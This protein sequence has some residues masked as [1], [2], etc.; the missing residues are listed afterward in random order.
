MPTTRIPTPPA[1]DSSLLRIGHSGSRGARRRCCRRPATPQ[2][3]PIRPAHR[4]AGRRPHPG[5]QFAACSTY[6]DGFPRSPAEFVGIRASCTA[7]I[8]AIARNDV[9][10][11][12]SC[13]P[14]ISR[15]NFRV[16]SVGLISTMCPPRSR[17]RA[18][19]PPPGRGTFC[20][21]R[22]LIGS[23]A[24]LLSARIV[25]DSITGTVTPAGTL[26]WPIRRAPAKKQQRATSDISLRNIVVSS[27][28]MILK[29]SS[30]RRSRAPTPDPAAL[31]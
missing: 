13:F 12:T 22:A 9:R 27:F 17:P 14:I 31:L 1:V 3:A 10:S 5:R 15:S 2:P 4:P 19:L 24:L 18:I 28:Q 30:L 21:T 20:I 23:P 8:E 7:S 26:V 29:T 6:W 11:G 25:V 16:T